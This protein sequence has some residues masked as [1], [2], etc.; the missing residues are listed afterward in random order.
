MQHAEAGLREMFPEKA[1]A[2]AAA[3]FIF[4]GAGEFL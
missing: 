2:T 3:F 1:A 4:C